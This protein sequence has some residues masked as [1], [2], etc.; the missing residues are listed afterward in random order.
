MTTPFDPQRPSDRLTARLPLAAA[1]LGLSV[2]G[3]AAANGAQTPTRGRQ[4]P[5]RTAPAPDRTQTVDLRTVALNAPITFQTDRDPQLSQVDVQSPFSEP[6]TM[7]L[8]RHELG[9]FM[10]SADNVSVGGTALILDDA[11]NGEGNLPGSLSSNSMGRNVRDAVSAD[12]DNDGR[13]EMVVLARNSDRFQVYRVDVNPQGVSSWQLLSTL[14]PL[15]TNEMV[16]G[17]L[18][19][20]DFDGDKRDE[21]AVFRTVGLIDGMGN[22]SSVWVL[23]D[24]VDGGGMLFEQ[25]YGASDEYGPYNNYSGIAA[26]VDGDGDEELILQRQGQNGSKGNVRFTLLDWSHDQNAFWTR[27]YKQWVFQN[28]L[29]TL[30]YQMTSKSAAGQFD[31]DSADEIVLFSTWPRSTTNAYL[32]VDQY[33][34]DVAANRFETVARATFSGNHEIVPFAESAIDVCAFDRYG[35]GKEWIGIISK[36]LGGDAGIRALRLNPSDGSWFS[37]SLSDDIPT[38]SD[39]VSL[40]AAD[41]NGD[42]TE[43]LY[44]GFSW[45]ASTYKSAWVELIYGDGV[46]ESRRLPIYGSVTS[47][48]AANTRPLILAPGEYDGDGLRVRY[49]GS[50][51][52]ISNPVPLTLLA[53]VPTKAGI[54]QNYLGS[55]SGYSIAMGSGTETTYSTSTTIT[56]AVGYEFEEFTGT[57]GA[58][59]KATMERESS[60]TS[61]SSTTTTFVTGYEAGNEADVIVFASNNY[62]VHE[63]RIMD[64]VEPGSVGQTFSIDVPLET[65][66]SKWTVPYYNSLVPLQYQMTSDLLPHTVGDPSTYRNFSE[67]AN[68]TAN[69]VSWRTPSII[70]VGQGLGGYVSSAIELASENA[71]TE[72]TELA[73]GAS[74][75]FKAFGVTAEGSISMGNGSAYTVSTNQET[76]YGAQIGDIAASDYSTWAYGIGLSVYQA[77]RIADTSNQPTGQW[78][79]GGYPLTVINFWVDPFGAGY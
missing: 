68:L 2:L 60:T 38:Q 6:E 33:N 39:A 8:E 75:S 66:I 78:L 64:A 49:Q 32:T 51:I 56:A 63:Y 70:N 47:T 74:A 62:L 29:P 79:P 35:D 12:I 77:W 7:L 59:V 25:H 65:R 15:S 30:G 76:V 18:T 1:V 46:T 61:T 57:F 19:V 24:P 54:N 73:L 71:T 9:F 36:T 11:A 17:T 40:A 53:A 67:M 14:D 34:F 48:S 52:R 50:T 45:G 55:S 27:V 4:L 23:D 5:P 21:I 20:G 26:D 13:D 16:E 42:S 10:A 41:S 31:G 69:L 44:A 3:A 58:T 28:T 43:E 22:T 37:D 72:Q